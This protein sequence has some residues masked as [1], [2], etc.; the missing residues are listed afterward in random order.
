MIDP[1]EVN[2]AEDG[3]EDSEETSVEQNSEDIA[4][5][6]P[7]PITEENE[8]VITPDSPLVAENVPT[9]NT[10]TVEIDPDDIFDVMY[11][12]PTVDPLIDEDIYPDDLLDENLLADNDLE[13]DSNDGDL[14][15]A[16]DILS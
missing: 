3:K 10:T 5:V 14:D 9:E 13:N 12:G 2:A 7:Q 4:V 6:E 16:G 15:I 11:G 8:V 1:E